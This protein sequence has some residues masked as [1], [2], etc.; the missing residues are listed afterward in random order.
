[1]SGV[2]ADVALGVPQEEPYQYLVPAAMTENASIGKRVLVPLRSQTR[3]GY[4]VGLSQTPQVE[5]PKEILEIIDLQSLVPPVI[6]DLTRWISDYYFCSWGQAL[7]A[8][9]PAPFKKGKT[10]MRTRKAK[11]GAAPE[12]FLHATPDTHVLT[13]DQSAAVERISAALEAKQAATFLFHG[14]TGSGKT[15]VYLIL[16]KKLLEQNRGAIVLVPEISLTPQATDRFRSRF[17][18]RVAVIH[19]RLS[20][21]KRL[22]EWHRIRTGE[23]KVVVGARSAVFSPVQDMGLIIIDEEHDDSYKQDETPRYDAWLVA[24]KRCEL[25]RAVLV[26]AS[27]TPRLESKREVELGLAQLVAL[28]DRIGRRQMPPVQIVDMKNQVAGRSIRVFSLPLESAVK[29]ALRQGEQ[30]MLFLNRRGFAPFINCLTCGYVASCPRCRVSLVFHFEESSLMCHLCN[31]K[32]RPP[33]ICPS[34]TKGY[35]RYLGLGTEKVESEAFRLFPGARIAR[36]DADTTQKAGSH[37]RI[38]NAFR[39][40]EIDIL[41]GTQMITK[42]HDFPG[43]SV[44][45][46]ISADTALHLPDFRAAERTF[47]LLAQVAG[48]AG[49]E[50][51]PGK[52]FIQT[53][54]PLHYAITAAKTHDY[55]GFYEKEMKFR[56]ELHMPPY[57]QL[58]QVYIAARD[59]RIVMRRSLEMRRD[60]EAPA[61]ASG[62]EILGPAPSIVSKR[63]GYFLWNLFYKAN[64]SKTLINFLRHH[65]GEFD[66]KGVQITVDIDPR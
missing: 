57:S 23:A 64:D 65:I 6:Y 37:E 45:G 24:E 29:E 13:P 62:V 10:I 3:I 34:C 12:E 66:K 28:P 14:V 39:K 32:T 52:V 49:R 27:A 33:K 25:E 42:G 43:V 20:P 40:K 1:M 15:E 63:R 21:G 11:G 19:S 55:A 44:I 53:Y 22:A 16:I 9:M 8:A 51:T 60:T 4:I 46:V 54:V 38:L 47:D 35:L 58:A 41:L 5:S 48:R 36:M 2:Y 17:G 50:D 59:E 26:R 56:E 61:A 7:E 30:V 18:D 31:H